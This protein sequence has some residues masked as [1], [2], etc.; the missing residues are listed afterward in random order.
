M[1]YVDLNPVRAKMADTPEASDFT[2]IQQRIREMAPEH[3]KSSDEAPTTPIPLMK[4]VSQHQYPH[5]NSIGFTLTDY[6]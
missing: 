2:S 1:S 4:L 3:V 5:P 6:L